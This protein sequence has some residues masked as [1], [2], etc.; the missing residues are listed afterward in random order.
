MR[1]EAWVVWAG[2]LFASCALTA[3]VIVQTL[4]VQKTLAWTQPDGATAEVSQYTVTQDG[5]GKVIAANVA[6]PTDPTVCSAAVTITSLGSHTWSVVATNAY[7]D[8]L[9]T[10]ITK[11][12]SSPGKSG[13]L[14]IK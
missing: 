4:P 14:T 5:V 8:S 7:G 1:R 13:N 3:A 10:S 11:L 6:C 9:P 2:L 12:V